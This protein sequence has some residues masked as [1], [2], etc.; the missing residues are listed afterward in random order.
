M[1]AIA[2]SSSDSE[3]D[4]SSFAAGSQR[5]NG[6]ES[7][8]D[9]DDLAYDHDGQPYDSYSESDHGTITDTFSDELSDLRSD[10]AKWAVQN[11]ATRTSVD[12][13][14]SV[15]RKH[16]HRLPKDARTLLG[17]PRQVEERELCGG[18]YLYFGLE[19][20]ILKIC[21]QYP[22]DFSRENHVLLNFNIDGL[23]LFKSS[24]VQIWPILC[25]VK[26]FQPF[27][28]AVFCGNEKP[29]SVSDFMSEFL[30]ELTRLQQD[31][32]AFKDET[33][34]VKVN[35]FICDAPAR[36]FLKCIKGH[37]GYNSCERCTIKGQY[38]NHRVVFNHQSQENVSSRTEEEF[39]RQSYSSHQSGHSP[40]VD[41]G[42][43]CIQSF[44][45]D[46]M[47]L[48]CLGVVRRLL[49]FL[50]QGPRECK[51][52]QRQIGEISF[53]LESLNGTLPREF[54]R[55]P[56]SL[57]VLDRWKAT[58]LRQFLLYTGPVALRAVLPES[59][60]HHFLTLTVAMSILL[61][62]NDYTRSAYTAYAEELLMYFY[63]AS[64]KL[65]SPIFPS[66]NVHSLTHLAEDVRNFGTSLNEICA[67]PFENHLQK[68]KRSVRN[69]KKPI[70]QL[71]KR[72]TEMDN[73]KVCITPALH[74]TFV[75]TKKKDSCFLVGD[76]FAFVK[77]KRTDKV[78]VCEVYHLDHLD[79]FFDTPCNS[80]LINIALLRDE[81]RPG[82]RKLI[83]LKDLRK[84]AVC[85]PY[86][87]GFVLI[88]MLHGSERH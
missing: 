13:L 61:D 16:G 38:V 45:L 77:K 31:G 17:T 29:N 43:L 80:K 46:Y 69:A 4:H 71:Y 79:S 65:Y 15:L 67:F 52:S 59:F 88:P 20:G 7:A 62:S 30:E 32:I 23:P 78:C 72:I 44:V 73:A 57:A 60:Y 33:L 74:R 87:N 35:A 26:R 75:S 22:D 36:A 10:L 6:A 49:T 40:L 18:Q 47:H 86:G 81:R 42:L 63:K 85:L 50:R 5:E 9:I 39:N 66:Y 64:T 54:A 12:E 56:W 41:V 3:E 76:G 27:I 68:L 84:K 83:E 82:K 51:L 48:V 28:V 37:T 53:K 21:S 11:K 58:E 19:S 8:A 70:T 25:S 14:L 2:L 55:Q 34:N 24:N 1:H